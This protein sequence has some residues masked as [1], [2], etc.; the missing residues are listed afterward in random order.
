MRPTL[1]SIDSTYPGPIMNRT[2]EPVNIGPT[3]DTASWN[4]DD[5]RWEAVTRRD[6]LADG[7]FSTA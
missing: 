3:A 6:P 7:A 1:V 2:A 5:E 4:S